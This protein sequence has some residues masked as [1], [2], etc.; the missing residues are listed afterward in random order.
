MKSKISE[1]LVAVHTHT[2]THTHTSMFTKKKRKEEALFNAFS[3][4]NLQDKEVMC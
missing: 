2:H 1:M 4:N 3:F